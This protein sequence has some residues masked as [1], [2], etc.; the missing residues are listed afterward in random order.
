MLYSYPLPKIDNT[1]H[2]LKLAGL[3]WFST[4]DLVVTGTLKLPMM[5]MPK[6]LTIPRLERCSSKVLPI[7]MMLSK[8]HFQPLQSSKHQVHQSLEGR[9]WIAQVKWHDLEFEYAEKFWP[10]V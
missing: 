3:Q 1:L 7:I 4:L 6:Q 9:R 5:I 2:T 8:M 10:L